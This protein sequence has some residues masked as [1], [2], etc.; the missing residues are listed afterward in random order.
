MD[1]KKLLELNLSEEQADKVLQLIKS[2]HIDKAKFEQKEAEVKNLQ[3]QLQERDEQ[4]SGL[5]KFEGDNEALK[6]KLKE[7]ETTNKAKADEYDKTLLVER[8][9]SAVRFALLEDESGKPHDVSMVAGMF[10]LD[11][12]ILNDDGTIATGFKEQNDTLRKD[13]GFLFNSVEQGKEDKGTKRFGSTPPDGQKK[14]PVTDTPEN[15][16]ARLAQS[17]LAMLGIKPKSDNNEQ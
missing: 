5:K 3:A 6:T 13:K 9:K 14:P 1:K 10:N 4:I 15:F 2:S 11:N 8:K 12:I 17:K 16:G 7:L